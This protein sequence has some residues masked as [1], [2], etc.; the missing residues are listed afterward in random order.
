MLDNLIR[1]IGTRFGLGGD[2]AR[3]IAQMLLAFITNPASGGI[4][5]FLSRLRSDGLEG[6]VQSWLGNSSTPQVPSGAQVES[7]FG[8]GGA[9][10]G[11]LSTIV[12]RLD[13]PRDKVV[14]V[15]G[16]LLPKLLSYLTPGGSVPSVLPAEITSLAEGGRGLLGSA[17]AGTAAAASAGAA[18]VSSAASQTAA[19][20]SSAGGGLG[21]WI[22]WIIGALI[23]IFGINYCSKK[24]TDLDAPPPTPTAAPAT[25]EAPAA[26]V[27]SAPA[28]PASV[29]AAPASAPAASDAAP[30]VPTGAAVLDSMAQDLP[31]LRVFFD[32]GKTDVA[33]EFNDKSKAFVDYL[34]ANADAKAVVSGFNDPTGDPVKNA[35]LSKQRAQAVQSALVAAGVPADRT[36]LEKPAET[37]DTGA[38]NAAS[39][40]VDVVVR[41]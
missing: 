1:E 13:L 34:K 5:G 32:T 14:G 20:A 15:V 4:T 2:Q 25:P 19:A 30:A 17:L 38:T 8:A 16:A 23:V 10:G 26:P 7:M 3:S 33:A 41:K 35:E 40:R 6:M 31:M 24:K 22:P 37:S 27:A 29:A 28:E 11:L 39:R 21:K 12:S 18:S 36:V 9:G